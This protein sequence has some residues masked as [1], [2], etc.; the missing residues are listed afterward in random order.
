MRRKR[1]TTIGS[2]AILIA[3]WQLV[4]ISV[5]Q[6]ELL[7]TVPRLISTIGESIA[8]VS[9][10]RTILSTMLRIVVCLAISLFSSFVM[11]ILFSSFKL[12]YE[13]FRPALAIMRS[14]PVISFILLA[15]IFLNNENIPLMI[16]FLT[17]F[18]LLT[19]NLTKGMQSLNPRLMIMAKM[20][21]IRRRN[22]HM[23][24]IYPQIAP[25]LYSGLT[26]AAGF[27]WRAIIMGEVLAQCSFGIGSEMKM[28]QNLIDIPNLLAWTIVAILMSYIFDRSISILSAVRCDISFL[29]RDCYDCISKHIT[30][31][32]ASNIGYH[33]GVEQFSYQFRHGMVYGLS[34]PSG[35]GKTTLLN[36]IGGI[37]NPIDGS[38]QPTIKEGISFVFQEPDLLPWLSAKDNVA[39]PLSSIMK[40][41]SAICRAMFY[42]RMMGIEDLAER[43]PE[44]ISYG[45]QQRVAIA[46]ALSFPSPILLM[47]EPFKGLDIAIRQHI[48]DSI[49]EIQQNENR[50]IIFTS[51]SH[52]ELSSLA[53][54]VIY[55]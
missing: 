39:L 26:S 29:K 53:D 3:L 30:N 51:H 7:P 40:R 14:I 12:I 11:A 54:K 2:I 19:E 22:R 5:D 21:N 41:E 20:F 43:L 6:P 35:R 33:Y 27:G 52:E 45:Q 16:G 31:I 55:L 44:E 49:K 48:I 4:A 8:S 34:G 37:L 28:A 38:V 9:F 32:T 13:L 17:M 36:M 46:R 18:P 1:L 23:L 25:F 10:Y 24:V 47:D 15:L 42:L 50:V